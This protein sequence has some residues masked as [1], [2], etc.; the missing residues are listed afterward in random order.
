MTDLFYM[1]LSTKGLGLTYKHFFFKPHTTWK[2]RVEGEVTDKKSNS[3]HFKIIVSNGGILSG[4][5]FNFFFSGK[6]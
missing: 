5:L 6:K 1:P 2:R 4:I 3:H